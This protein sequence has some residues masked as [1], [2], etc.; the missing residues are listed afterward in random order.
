MSPKQPES[1]HEL[2]RHLIKPQADESKF[3]K[4]NEP[5]PPQAKTKKYLRCGRK[6]YFVDE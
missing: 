4:E 6:F 2:Q 1:N 5:N 3:K